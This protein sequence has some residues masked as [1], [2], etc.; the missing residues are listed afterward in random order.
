MSS[1]PP[2]SSAL[3]LRTALAAF[4]LVLCAALAVLAWSN[5]AALPGGPLLAVLFALGAMAAVVDLAVLRRRRA[6]RR[7]AD[8]GAGRSGTRSLFE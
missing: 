7:Q 4:G 1:F 5:R 8:L 2:A 3:N 6:T